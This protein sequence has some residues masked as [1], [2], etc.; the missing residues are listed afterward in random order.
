[1]GVEAEK[2]II[3]LVGQDLWK[4]TVFLAR[5]FSSLKST[6]VRMICLGASDINLS[7]VVPVESTEESVRR[8]HEEFFGA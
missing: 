7:L 2:S 1:V 5:V 8:L 6:P 4:D 3:C